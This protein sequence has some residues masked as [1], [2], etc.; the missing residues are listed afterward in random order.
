ML[1]QYFFAD[2]LLVLVVAQFH[3]IVNSM[4]FVYSEYSSNSCDLMALVYCIENPK[5][6]SD[7]MKGNLLHC[8]RLPFVLQSLTF[9]QVKCYLSQNQ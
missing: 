3:S 5:V 8:E 6:I 2:I 4:H 9:Y 7:R 1:R